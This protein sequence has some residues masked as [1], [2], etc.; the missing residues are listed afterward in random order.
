MRSNERS[1]GYTAGISGLSLAAL[2]S[3]IM[4]AFTALRS[5][6]SPVYFEPIPVCMVRGGLRM[7]T[8]ADLVMSCPEDFRLAATSLAGL[9]VILAITVF[10]GRLRNQSVEGDGDRYLL[11]LAAASATV[12]ICS[13]I[14]VYWS[15]YF[16][17][18]GKLGKWYVLGLP[19]VVTLVH[20]PP[21]KFLLLVL[22]VAFFG[23]F[24]LILVTIVTGFP[25]D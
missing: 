15:E 23:F 17:G 9:L 2:V 19:V 20:F 18:M 21:R 1:I 11:R 16:G 22:P 6:G 5:D 8:P 24:G 7:G 4:V 14:G 12:G 3:A 25:L 13:L 10:V